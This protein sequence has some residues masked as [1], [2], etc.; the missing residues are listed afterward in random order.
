MARVCVIINRDFFR[1][2]LLNG[3][4]LSYLCEEFYNNQ[5]PRLWEWLYKGNSILGSLSLAVG[6]FI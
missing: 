5:S 1:R 2:F 6:F 3:R 4:F